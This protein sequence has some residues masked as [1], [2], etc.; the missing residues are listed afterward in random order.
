[1]NKSQQLP[2]KPGFF[3]IA[4]NYLTPLYLI[5]GI[6]FLFY[7]NISTVE[8]IALSLVW[9][10]LLPPIIGRVLLAI[11]GRPDTTCARLGDKQYNVWWLLTQIQMLYNRITLLEEILRLLPGIYPLWL[12]LWGSKVSLFFFCSPGVVFPDRYMLN[13]GKGVVIGS[14]SMISG[15]LASKSED[16]QYQL[17]VSPV[18]LEENVLLGADVSL[19]PGCHIH[20]NEVI[21]IS[22]YLPPYTVW[23][24]GMREKDMKYV[25]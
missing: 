25:I 7:W 12:R 9:V 1:M 8:V 18:T 24:N 15:H 17:I 6:L 3:I 4:A 14:R 13:I 23:K 10:Y 11:L 20:K 5:A 2:T 21:R 16:G 22:K 19:A